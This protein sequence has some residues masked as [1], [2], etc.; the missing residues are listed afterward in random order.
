[1]PSDTSNS[2]NITIEELL[3]KFSSGS[4]R[5]RLRLVNE[6]ESRSKELCEIGSKLFDNFDKESDE[7]TVGWI[8]QVL[9]RHQ[10]E[11]LSKFL[12]KEPIGW[13]MAS[14]SVGIDYDPLQK[15]LLEEN[16]EEADRITSSILRELAG[17]NAMERGYVY[18]SEVNSID[19]VD[20]VSLDRLWTAYSQGKFGFS[21][22]A[23]LLDSLGGSYEKLWPRIGWKIDGVW[24]RYPNAFTWSLKAPEGHMPLINQLRGVRLMNEY[25]NHHSLQARRKGK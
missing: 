22:Q 18:F 10:K 25:M 15:N 21:V 7:W 23:R 3:E 5:Q 17:P 2:T 12:E 16:F 24:T 19:G 9:N 6:I 11:F 8:F 13:F 1:M 4:Q 20:L 14:S